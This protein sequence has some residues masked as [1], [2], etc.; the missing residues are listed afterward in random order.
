MLHI[1]AATFFAVNEQAQVS[2][3]NPKWSAR[4]PYFARYKSHILME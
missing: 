1:E 3:L 4:L 2:Y